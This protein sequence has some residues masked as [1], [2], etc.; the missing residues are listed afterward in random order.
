MVGQERHWWRCS[1]CSSW[2]SRN[3]GVKQRSW[4]LTPGS[5]LLVKAQHSCHRRCQNFGD[6]STMGWPQNPAAAMKRNQL[7]PKT[8]CVLQRAKLETLPKLFGRAQKIV[9][10]SQILDIELFM[11]LECGFVWLW[12]PS[13]SKKVLTYFFYFTRAHSW[14]KVRT[15]KEIWGF[16]KV[17]WILKLWGF[18]IL[19]CLYCNVDL[20]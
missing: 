5:Q 19:K 13:W 7:K 11:L 20:C 4:G 2:K 10:R 9:S 8:P 18:Y 3:R 14:K 16:R 6:A 17:F 12:L 15:F 1:L